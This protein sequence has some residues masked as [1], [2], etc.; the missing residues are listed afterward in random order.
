MK[1]TGSGILAALLLAG[2]IHADWHLAREHEHGALSGAHPQHWLLGVLVFGLLGLFLSRRPAAERW[3]TSAL[4]IA[5]GAVLG[6]IVEP[7][8]EMISS[9]LSADWL[10][11]G[12][13]WTAFGEF[14]AAGLMAFLVTM[15]WRVPAA[16]E[17]GSG[18]AGD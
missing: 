8:A 13:R 15:A 6:Q 3:R 11:Q 9:G 2:A 5:G 18:P 16:G 4:V 1:V 7:L 17:L 12:P 10:V 14:F